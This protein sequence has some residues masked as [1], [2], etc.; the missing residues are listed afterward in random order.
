MTDYATFLHLGEDKKFQDFKQVG[1]E[2]VNATDDVTGKNRGISSSPITLSI[3][4]KN[5]ITELFNIFE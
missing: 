4:S 3:Y 1:K 5:G 2:I